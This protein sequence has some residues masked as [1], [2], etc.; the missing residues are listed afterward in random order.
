[1]LAGSCSA[2]SNTANSVWSSLSGD[3]PGTI[4]SRQADERGGS[5]IPIPPAT[6]ESNPLP[7]LNQRP[8]AP[9]LGTGNFAATL[10]PGSPTGTYVG[11]K[12]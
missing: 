8:A 7:T 5:V 2:V 6:A 1:M 3:D 9:A 12:V 10:T 4:S 11:A